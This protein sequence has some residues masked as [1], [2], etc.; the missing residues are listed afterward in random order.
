MKKYYHHKLIMI[1]FFFL[2]SIIFVYS[3]FI[4]DFSPKVKR[5]IVPNPEPIQIEQKFKNLFEFNRASIENERAIS[6]N[7]FSMENYFLK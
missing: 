5:A 3:T 7:F 2:L 1:I 6:K 4:K